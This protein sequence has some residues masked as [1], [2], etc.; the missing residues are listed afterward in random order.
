MEHHRNLASKLIP[1]SPSPVDSPEPFSLKY[2]KSYGM[3]LYL[4]VV[5]YEI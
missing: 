1:P 4:R 2:H 3:V 5:L